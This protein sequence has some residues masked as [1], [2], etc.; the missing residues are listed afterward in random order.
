MK[1]RFAELTNRLQQAV[2]FGPGDLDPNIR[3]AAAT[4]GDVPEPMKRYAEKVALH[5]YKVTDE[6]VEAL[7]QAGYSEDQI[8]ELTV[9]VALGAALSRRNAG[10]ESLRRG[11]SDAT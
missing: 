6:D 8:F 11:Q 5:A 10:L 7:L 2:L 4:S 3:Q 1:D 9:S